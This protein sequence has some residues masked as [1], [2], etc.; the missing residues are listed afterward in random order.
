MGTVADRTRA[1]NSRPFTLTPNSGEVSNIVA[2][3]AQK[4]LLINTE[5]NEINAY[6][7]NGALGP[8]NV[9]FESTS[10]FGATAVQPV[11][12][13]NF[14]TFVQANGFKVRDITFSF[15]EDQ[16]KSTDLSFVADHFFYNSD[17]TS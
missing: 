6:G 7:S 8:L 16:Y 12:I 2:M 13:N 9:V 4:T 17:S 1:D 14:M 5:R 15:A 3:S 10:S 11:R